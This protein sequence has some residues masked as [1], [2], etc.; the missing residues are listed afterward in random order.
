MGLIFRRKILCMKIRIENKMKVRRCVCVC[1]FV[2][3]REK[4]ESEIR[5]LFRA[6]WGFVFIAFSLILARYVCLV[7]LLTLKPSP[8]QS[9]KKV[10]F[11]FHHCDQFKD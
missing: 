5:S 6:L 9:V 8:K 4:R 7:R 3:V 2:C 11:K 1:V 10:F